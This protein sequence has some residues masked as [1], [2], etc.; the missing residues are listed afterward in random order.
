MAAAAP[1]RE[2]RGRAELCSVWQRQGPKE[3]HGA[4]SGQGQ[5]GVRERVCLMPT[6]FQPV[7][8][9]PLSLVKRHYKSRWALQ[10][11]PQAWPEGCHPFTRW[12]LW[13]HPAP[14]QPPLLPSE[15]FQTQQVKNSTIRERL[16]SQTPAEAHTAYLYLNSCSEAEQAEHLQTQENITASFWKIIIIHKM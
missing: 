9:A 2:R 14:A 6:P 12:Q 1:H 5:L 8:S 16:H 10:F 4:A 15:H 3:R 13:G 11:L 7:C